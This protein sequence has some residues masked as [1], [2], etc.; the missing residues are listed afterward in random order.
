MPCY[1]GRESQHFAVEEARREFRHNSDVA[2][3]LCRLMRQLESN[4]DELE[5]PVSLQMWWYEHKQR[6]KGIKP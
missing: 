1:D 3:M 4:A 5:I 2:E 6:D